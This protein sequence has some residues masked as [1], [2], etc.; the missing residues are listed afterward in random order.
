MLRIKALGAGANM[1]SQYPR[2]LNPSD[3]GDERHIETVIAATLVP[4]FIERW[5]GGHPSSHIADGFGYL[6]GAE[7]LLRRI[8]W[9]HREYPLFTGVNAAL[10]IFLYNTWYYMD[11]LARLVG[12]NYV[13]RRSESHTWKLPIPQKLDSL[14]GCATELFLLIRKVADF[15][16]KVRANSAN[17]PAIIREAS[18]LQHKIQSWSPEVG[19]HSDMQVDPSDSQKIR[20]AIQTAEAHRYAT[21]LYLHQAAPEVSSLSCEELA[22]TTLKFLATVPPPSQAII[23][24][25]YPLLVAGCEA[26]EEEDRQWVSE[27][28]QFIASRMWVGN[29]DR[30]WE[31]TQ[32]V[33]KRRD[34]AKAFRK[35]HLG[36]QSDQ[37][38]LPD[39]LQTGETIEDMDP[40]LTVRGGLH[41]AGVMK[42]WGWE[43]S[44]YQ[45]HKNHL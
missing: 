23:G 11:I 5:W 15:C 8:A 39:T 22:K 2:F 3:E 37:H 25:I 44:F 42:D 32:E 33:W 14:M 35:G 40:E 4:A 7:E 19:L 31:I 1:L 30:C 26:D 38:Q 34:A 20:D 17:S 24:Q 6:R 36:A 16:V 28:W 13:M 12:G 10:L 27:R 21:L 9:C 45:R 41:W 43:V 29:V 18:I